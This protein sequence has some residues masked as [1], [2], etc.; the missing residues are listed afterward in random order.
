MFSDYLQCAGQSTKCFLKETQ[1]HKGSNKIEVS[2]FSIIVQLAQA[3]G[4]AVACPSGTQA[5]PL[6]LFYHL[7]GQSFSYSIFLPFGAGSF[8][9]VGLPCG[10]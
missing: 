7:I 5:P 4:S 8:L 3:G 2:S 1:E 6:S 10:L 9:V